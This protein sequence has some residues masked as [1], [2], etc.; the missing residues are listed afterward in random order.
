MR[1]V[2]GTV[3]R[4]EGLGG[5]HAEA[6][7]GKARIAWSKASVAR[8]RSIS[9]QRLSESPQWLLPILCLPQELGWSSNGSSP[10]SFKR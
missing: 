10:W 6:R 9:P 5:S 8:A 7:H 2:I 3:H 1:K 4:S